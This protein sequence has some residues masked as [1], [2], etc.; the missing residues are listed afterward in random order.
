MDQQWNEGLSYLRPTQAKDRSEICL[1]KASGVE[2]FLAWTAHL[3]P[4][5]LLSILGVAGAIGVWKSRKEQMAQTKLWNEMRN[6]KTFAPSGVPDISQEN[7]DIAV[8]LFS[9]EKLRHVDGPRFDSAL[10]DRGLT[11]GGTLGPRKSVTIGPTAFTSWAVLGSTLGHEIEVHAKQSFLAVVLR[12]RISEV[13]LSARRAL[14]RYVPALDPSAK[15]MFDN[16]GTWRAEREAYLYELS[17]ASRFGLS[18]GER[19]SIRYVMDYYYPAKTEPQT[20]T[21]LEP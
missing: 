15:E 13:Q 9:I 18:P 11:T 12:D 17:Q 7:V 8:V 2:V 16:D 5:M 10:E 20:V 19:Q 21:P 1:A 3:L 6:V 4:L 14:S